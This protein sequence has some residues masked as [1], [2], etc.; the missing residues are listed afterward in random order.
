V[1]AQNFKD[2]SCKAA[3]SFMDRWAKLISEED[4]PEANRR[5][6]TDKAMITN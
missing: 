6:Q 1:D 3:T 2:D 4:K 5:A